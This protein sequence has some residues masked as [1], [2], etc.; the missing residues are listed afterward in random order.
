[1]ATKKINLRCTGFT[2]V[3][4]MVTVAIIAILASVALPSYQNYVTEMRRNAAQSC[5]LELVQF[6][7]RYY[8]TQMTYVG[9]TLPTLECRTNMATHYTFA[10]AA[11]PTATAYTVRATA[12]GGQASRDAN[13]TPMQ[14]TQSG[15]R[16]PS[17]GCWK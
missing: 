1:M 16:T 2:L 9:A 5:M 13:C 3:E 4:L 7:E 11:D 6:T 8:S 12:Q 10:Y 15:A 17:T 14:I